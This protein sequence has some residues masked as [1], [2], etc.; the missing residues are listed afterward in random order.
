MQAILEDGDSLARITAQRQAEW[1]K[2]WEHRERLQKKL[3]E[4]GLPLVVELGRAPLPTEFGDWTYIVYGDLVSGHHH[5][6]L[7]FG[8]LGDELGYS[9]FDDVLV[10]LHSS[11]LTSEVFH[12]VNCECREELHSAM[13]A[14]QQEGMGIILYVDQEGRGTGMM[15]KLCQLNGMFTWSDSG[16]IEQQVDSGGSPIDTDKAYRNAGYPSE[17]RDYAVAIEVLNLL[18]V[19]SVR[20]ITNNPR[21]IAALCQAGIAVNP[22]EIHIPP[23]NAIVANDLKSKADNLGHSIRPEHYLF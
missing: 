1:S 5:S 4:K 19:S 9:G 15:G 17:C 10:R 16:A 22:I 6:V 2:P 21:K 14:I 20:L 7:C 23:S 18:Q 11:C 12:A 13:A 8:Q 3:L